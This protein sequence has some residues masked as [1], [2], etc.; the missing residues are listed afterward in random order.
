MKSVLLTG[1][2]PF[3]GETV[4]PSLEAVKR[5]QGAAVEGARLEAL[6]MPTVFGKC[7]NVLEKAIDALQPDI[8]IAVGQAGG[9]SGITVERIAIN[10]DDAPI[11]DNEGNRPI[12]TPI[13]AGGPAAYWST[14]PVKTIV[15]RLRQAGIP[16]SVSQTAG[17]FVCNHLFYGLSHLLATRYPGTRGGFIHIPYLPKQAAAYPDRPS[18]SLEVI[19]RALE[20]AVQTS[21]ACG[22]E[23]IPVEGGQLH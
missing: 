9:R 2:Q 19:V 12:D 22:Q 7:L 17:T 16:A 10:I 20:I 11:P 1:F 4:N 3:G 13:I 15:S 21:I 8:V 23:V 18:M 5:L 14:L 6:E